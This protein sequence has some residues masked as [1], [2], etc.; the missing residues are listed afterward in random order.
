MN[1]QAAIP[2]EAVARPR[3]RRRLRVMARRKGVMPLVEVGVV[4]ALVAAVTISFFLVAG[5]TTPASLLTPPVAAAMLVANLIPATAL[6]VLIA[7]RLAMRRAARSPIGGRGRLHVRF[8]ALF[9]IIATV[10]TL[11]V[12]F[13]ASMLFQGAIQF[14][15]SDRARTVLDSAQV[16]SQS[17]VREHQARIDRE[18]P[19]MRGDVVANINEF[20]LDTPIFA[21]SML[22]Q[23][24]NRDLTE[25]AIFRVSPRG[26]VQTFAM[27]N[28][29]QRPVDQRL[30]RSAL[31]ALRT[32]QARIV[33]DAGDRIEALIKLD[34]TQDLYLYISRRMDSRALGQWREAQSAISDYRMT[35]NRSR[36]LQLR[37]NAI[38]LAVSL[39]IVAIVI[40]IALKL[41]DRLVRPVA[42]LVGAARLA[43]TGDLS[44]RV[45]ESKARDE[46]ATL[47]N[48]FNRMTSRLEAQTGALV[49]ANSQ[50][51]S[52]R[53]FT[54][55][56]L[57]GVTAGVVSVDDDH[58]IRLINSSAEDLLKTG[59]QSPVGQKLDDLAP[60]LD[61]QLTSEEREDVVQ[62]ASRGEPRTLAVKT[63][64]VKGGYVLTFDDITEQLLDQRRA[65]WSD[66]ARR[67]AHEIKNPL[68]PIQLAAERLQRR[69][70]KEI[71]N[72]PA[73]F[74]RLT[75]T[76][77]RQVGD[78]RRMVDE[79]SDFARM[80]KPAF[81]EEPLAEIARQALFLHEVAHPEIGFTLD[82]A[83]PPPR[84]VCDRRLL[85]QALTNIVKNGVEAIEQKRAERAPIKN[86][87][88]DSVAMT[89]RREGSKI[90]IEVADTGIGLPAE[91]G[92][93]TEPY[94]TTRAKG[95]GL[96]LAIVKKIVEEHFGQIEFAD[97]ATGGATVR[98]VFDVETLAQLDRSAPTVSEENPPGN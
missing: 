3:W 60:E 23:V 85:G 82:V 80:P 74:E 67:I 55:A 75:G 31:P 47:G 54:E 37:F 30:P 65:A 42:E 57:A 77:V 88:P 93:L 11:L 81:A 97:V 1:V 53:A 70:G 28:F 61:R 43:T 83:N 24:A 18:L 25:A 62:L 34:P 86:A 40:F 20:G 87:L 41:A 66:V 69:Y 71:E 13:F 52:R 64:R 35:L 38:L 48:A 94:M 5:R 17:Y 73:T 56:V 9:S 22:G 7:R 39:L 58:V 95:T 26:D 72:D 63:V 50:L 33:T 27:V 19:V 51:D 8:V 15:Y 90:L 14:W 68:T 32:G 98:L 76:I 78:L 92:R 4:L 91:R 6:M 96:G 84:L 12:V 59:G 29:D 45:P 44:A 21:E 10:P 79:F 46:V 2:V 49:T 89:I 16:V 36:D